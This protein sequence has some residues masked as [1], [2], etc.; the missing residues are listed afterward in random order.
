MT[1]AVYSDLADVV[2][3]WVADRQ[4]SRRKLAFLENVYQQSVDS[5]DRL[6]SFDIAPRFYCEELDVPNATYWVQVIA[7]LLDFL[8]PTTGTARYLQVT[9]LLLEHDHLT[10][11]EA[12][13]AFNDL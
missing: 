2:D 12:E 8:K 6:A 10:D 9:Q 1:T 4:L 11:E 13:A 7:S 5:L 3:L